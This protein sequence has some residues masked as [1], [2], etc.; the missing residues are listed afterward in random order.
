[1]HYSLYIVLAPYKIRGGGNGT[2]RGKESS[3][4]YLISLTL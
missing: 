4:Y 1:M 3:W 2:E